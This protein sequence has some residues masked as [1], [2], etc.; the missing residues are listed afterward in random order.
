MHKYLDNFLLISRLTVGTHGRDKKE[1]K[2]KEAGQEEE[3]EEGP[4]NE[5]GAML[6]PLAHQHLVV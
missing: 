6:G 2:E 5:I 4:A 1:K 3:E